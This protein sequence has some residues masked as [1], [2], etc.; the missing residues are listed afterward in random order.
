MFKLSEEQIKNAVELFDIKETDVI[1]YEQAQ[2][3]YKLHLGLHIRPSFL[4]GPD[5][6]K[7]N[8]INGEFEQISIEFFMVPERI[9]YYRLLICYQT[10]EIFL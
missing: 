10:Q 8:I 3:A 1:S 7:P 4:E 2:K 5:K 9:I 6:I